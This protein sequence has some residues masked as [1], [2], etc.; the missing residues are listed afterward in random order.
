MF[1]RR[2][3]RAARDSLLRRRTRTACEIAAGRHRARRPGGARALLG[4]REDVPSLLAGANLLA[5]PSRFEGLPIVAL[6]AMSLG[7]PVV[8]TRVCG[9][10]EA[11][12]D[13]STGRLVPAG[14]AGALACALDE[15]LS[16]PGYSSLGG[17]G[18]AEAAR[19]VRCRPHGCRD[20]RRLRRGS[21]R[22][23]R[24]AAKRGRPHGADSYRLRRRRR[25]C[26]PP[27]RK[28]P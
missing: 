7:L 26:Q 25:D 20:S 21:R 14:D 15:V 28:S 3:S 22:I 18:P 17:G 6:E 19:E 1:P 4:R 2:C 27:S 13:G 24:P 8:G 23:Q 5:M 10:T 11:V 12:V 16:S 9:L